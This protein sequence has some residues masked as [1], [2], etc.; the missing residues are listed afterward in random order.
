MGK[1]EKTTTERKPEEEED[2]KK[3]KTKK[4]KKKGNRPS[5]ENQLQ[6]EGIWRVSLRREKK[7]KLA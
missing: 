5:S 7:N 1:G 2:E 3:T 4:K 6:V